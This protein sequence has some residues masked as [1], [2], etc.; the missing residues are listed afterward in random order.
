MRIPDNPHIE[1]RL[2]TSDDYSKLQVFCDQCRLLGW[3]NTSSFENIKLDKMMMPWGQ[4][5]IGYDHTNDA[6]Y[7]LAGVHRLPEIAPNAWRC[8]FRNCKL[9][10]YAKPKF[11]TKNI[12]KTGYQI[13][14][15]L[16]LQMQFIKQIDPTAEFYIT[17][18]NNNNPT[19]TSGKGKTTNHTLTHTLHKLNVLEKFIDDMQLYY[20]HQTVWKVNESQYYN[21]REQQIG[22]FPICLN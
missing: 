20:T 10:M 16:P 5:F 17:T 14:Y 2:L 22:L 12:Y 7:N 8:M 6:I 21:I 1:I 18:N 4:F 19:D 13:S 11:F 3:T 15:F 9:P